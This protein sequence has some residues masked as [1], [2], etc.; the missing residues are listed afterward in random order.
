[1]TWD[2][3][4]FDCDGVLIDSEPINNLLFAAAVSAL[5]YPLS[6]EECVREFMGLPTA[7]C[8]TRGPALGR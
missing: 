7:A 5:G 3:V 1:M 2:L 6:Y 4:I 8:P